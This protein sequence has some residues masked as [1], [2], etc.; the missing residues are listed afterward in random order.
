MKEIKIIK[1]VSFLLFIIPLFA[2]L[3]ALSAANHLVSYKAIGFPNGIQKEYKFKCDES[4][5]FCRN[6]LHKKIKLTEFSIKKSR[7]RKQER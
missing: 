1:L 7:N 4:N 3:F 6:I 2:L 5:N